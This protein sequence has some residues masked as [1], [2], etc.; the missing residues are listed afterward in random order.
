ME[1][2]SSLV[3]P[4]E[5]IITQETIKEDAHEPEQEATIE[6]PMGVVNII[7]VPIFSAAEETA[8]TSLSLPTTYYPC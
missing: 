3:S 6:F 7:I 1:S 8:S 4:L 2:Q 5:D